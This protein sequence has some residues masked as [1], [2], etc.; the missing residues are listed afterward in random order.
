[1]V[2]FPKSWRY[3]LE[4]LGFR[5]LEALLRALPVET[6]SAWSGAA[7]RRLAPLSSRHA[8]A[9]A[10]LR[11]ALPAATEQERETIA[12]E[13]W[14]NLGRTFAESFHLPEIVASDRLVVADEAYWGARAAAEGGWVVCSAHVGNWEIAVAGLARYGRRTAGVYQKISN[15]LVDARVRAMRAFLYPGGLFPKDRAVA[16]KLV[17]RVRCGDALAILADLRDRTGVEVPFFGTPAP[18]TTFPAVI[19]RRLG[20]P[21]FVGRVLRQ[22]NVRFFLEMVEIPVPRTQ[23]RDA[24]V[25]AATLAVQR[26]L[27]DWIR[28]DPGQWMWAHR[29]WG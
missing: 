18:T 28:A 3:R 29:R 11:R 2:T 23:D 15:P 26:Q 13:M 25:R 8:R 6:A 4:Y 16:V 24:D 5:M 20:A 14:E 27:E 10:Q 12:R 9:L 7:W 1:M 17:H 22:P 21:L 19:A